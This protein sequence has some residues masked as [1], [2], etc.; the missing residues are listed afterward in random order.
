MPLGQAKATNQPTAPDQASKRQALTAMDEEEVRVCTK[1]ALCQSR[2][3]TVFGEGDPDAGLMFIGEGP[4]QN[5]DEQRRPFVGRAGDLL[6]KQIKAMGFE[7]EQVFIANIVKCRPPNNRT[8][9]SDE[10]EAC[11]DY[12][13]RQIAVIQPKVIV[14][15]GGPAAKMMLKTKEGITRIRGTWFSYG[16]L[17][18]EGPAIPIM[19]TFHP[20]Y[21]LRAYT[22]DN[23]QKV[24]SD[25]QQAMTLLEK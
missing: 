12:L 20:A 3:N 16:G 10:V 21:L 8:P 18:P 2:T 4:G 23:R 7:R 9:A 17:Q 1:C 14:T 6:N 19:P 13:R 15:L 22:T 25:L 11:S 5:E 24:W